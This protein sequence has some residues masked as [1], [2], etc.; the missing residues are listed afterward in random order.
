MSSREIFESLID[1]INKLEVSTMALHIYVD[2]DNFRG[3]PIA[4][5]VQYLDQRI[6]TLESRM[7]VESE[8][9]D[10]HP[11]LKDLYEKYQATKK[12]LGED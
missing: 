9:Q 6:N 4:D 3:Q 7:M 12:L 8:L 2:L 11:A 10:K 5:V 1:R